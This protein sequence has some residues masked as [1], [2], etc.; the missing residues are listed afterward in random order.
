MIRKDILTR[1]FVNDWMRKVVALVLAGMVYFY[2]ESQT[3]TYAKM[4]V[5]LDIIAGPGVVCTGGVPQKFVE[6]QLRGPKSVLENKPDSES[7]RGRITVTRENEGR[8]GVF[9]VTLTP[10]C[11]QEYQNV[12]VVKVTD[13]VIPLPGFQPQITKRLKV[14]VETDGELS[15]NFM[16]EKLRA[17]PGEVTVIGPESALRERN[18]ISTQ[19]IRLSADQTT[20]FTQKVAVEKWGDDLFVEPEEI[21]V[22]CAIARATGKRTFENL[23]VLI[24]EKS[25]DNGMV[26]VDGK[27][28][29]QVQVSG[30]PSEINQLTNSDINVYVNADEITDRKIGAVYTRVIE[31]NV[32]RPGIK[33]EAIVPGEAKLKV[34]QKR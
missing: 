28:S 12:K 8:D 22:E 17:I 23:P 24:A 15:T 27:L 1:I 33:V 14:K 11:F 13:P 7:F 26:F 21:T 18:E 16:V 6:V 29:C 25:G 10:R 9:R 5:P 19:K 2:V 32:K 31:C 34:M 20:S 4:E 3:Q 30:L